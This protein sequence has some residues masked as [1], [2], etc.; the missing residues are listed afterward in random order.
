MQVLKNIFLL[1]G[2]LAG[3]LALV[4]IINQS[5]AIIQFAAALHPWAGRSTFL[6]LLAFYAV[7]F[8]Y[9]AIA[10]LRMPKP[11]LPPPERD[12]EAHEQFI[13]GLLQRLRAN[14][15]LAGHTFE[16]SSEEAVEAAVLVLDREADAIISRTA[17]T[18]F[19][20]TAVSQNG[21]LDGLMVLGGLSRMVWQIAH[22]Y[23]QRPHW[24]ELLSLYNNVVL[25]TFLATQIDDLDLKERIEPIIRSA[26]GSGLA[27]AVPG[28]QMLGAILIGS[29]LEGTANSFL[30]LR[31]GV[32]SKRYCGALVRPE[33]SLLCRSAT[34]EA[35]A[36]LGSVVVQSSGTVSRALADALKKTGKGAI[37]SIGQNVSDTAEF[38]RV[39]MVRIAQ[40]IAN[41]FGPE[42]P[43][44]DDS[45]D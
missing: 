41:A 42:E 38:A 35:A 8:G 18:V 16:G 11:L 23:N 24:R 5:V 9:P 12:G 30:T 22:H 17:S 27:T 10:L 44:R 29:L 33:R 20:G 25:A 45:T 7:A 21:R 4:F 14:P 19:I 3:L 34:V 37:T 26:V 6:L 28:F 13:A 40:Q 43:T 31:V 39:S 2:T 15:A 36:L 32:I 1:A